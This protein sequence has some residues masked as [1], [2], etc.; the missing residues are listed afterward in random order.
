MNC[1]E[2]TFKT[3]D[4][5]IQINIYWTA[6]SNSSFGAVSH[7]KYFPNKLSYKSTYTELHSVIALL[8]QFPKEST[9]QT[10]KLNYKSTYTEL[11]LVIALLVQFPKESTFQTD[12]LN[13]KST[14]TELHSVIA[15]LVQ[16]PKEST[17]QTDK[18]G[19]KSTCTEL[20]T[21]LKLGKNFSTHTLAVC[22]YMYWYIRLT[23]G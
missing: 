16:F 22:V 8:V 20:Y 10:D 17:F 13:Y 11:H 3:D 21:Q 14:Y 4:F 9:F 12:K 19:Y 7:R 15:L 5:N 1:C 6:L 2:S 23:A 18:L